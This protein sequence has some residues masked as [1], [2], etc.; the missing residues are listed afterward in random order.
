MELPS[1]CFLYEPMEFFQVPAEH[2]DSI[3]WFFG[4]KQYFNA[5]HRC[6]T[7]L[8]WYIFIAAKQTLL[9]I[10]KWK[11]PGVAAMVSRCSLLIA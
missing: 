2:W 10:F 9:P 3:T 7:P 11:I 4:Y 8:Y 5:Q 1:A 6:V